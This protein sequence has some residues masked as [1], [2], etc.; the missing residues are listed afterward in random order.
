MKSGWRIHALT[1]ACAIESL[2]DRPAYRERLHL[3]SSQA[4][5][6]PDSFRVVEWRGEVIGMSFGI[7]PAKISSLEP[8]RQKSYL[9]YV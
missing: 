4:E 7:K 3:V 5:C 8:S 1:N 2:K 6:K 9:R